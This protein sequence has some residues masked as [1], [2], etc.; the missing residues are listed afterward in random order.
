MPPTS[1]IDSPFC[2]KVEY[3]AYLKLPA[4]EQQAA[5]ETAFATLALTEELI[6]APL[7]SSLQ[8][9]ADGT[10]S[11]EPL[12]FPPARVAKVKEQFVQEAG[13]PGILPLKRVHQILFTA[14]ERAEYDFDTWDV[15][16]QATCEGCGKTMAWPDVEKFL[17]ENL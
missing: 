14:E 5:L 7:P 3:E 15:D 6:K 12:D 2:S 10:I 9:Y 16:L 11:Y 1:F 4:G 8:A 17:S 13:P